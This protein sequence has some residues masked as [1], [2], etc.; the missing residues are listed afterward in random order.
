MSGKGPEDFSNNEELICA[1]LADLLTSTVPDGCNFR[2]EV[3]NNAIISTIYSKND[4]LDVTGVASDSTDVSADTE[5]DEGYTYNGSAV[6]VYGK[7]KS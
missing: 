3:E 5:F 1:K 2:I 6:G 7:Y 4:S